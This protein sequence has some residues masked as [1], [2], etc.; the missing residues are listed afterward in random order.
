M[1]K[2]HTANLRHHACLCYM[3]FCQLRSGLTCFLRHTCRAHF[4]AHLFSA[5]SN[6]KLQSNQAQLHIPFLPPAP[7]S[8][9]PPPLPSRENPLV[10]LS[11]LPDCCC[12]QSILCHRLQQVRNLWSEIPHIQ[13]AV[14]KLSKECMDLLNKIFVVDDKKRITIEAIKSHPW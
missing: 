7:P 10:S 5:I 9:P 12:S 14:E 3:G 6:S 4:W 1:H 2:P 11:V 8:C 13:K